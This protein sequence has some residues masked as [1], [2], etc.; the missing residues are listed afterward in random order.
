M[1]LSVQ[2]VDVKSQCVDERALKKQR[3]THDIN[4]SMSLEMRFV[5]H[6]L[7]IHIEFDQRDLSYA[8]K[9]NFHCK[10]DKTSVDRK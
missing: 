1:L 4:D 7:C 2:S 9:H 5:R 3:L 6:K 8:L 10:N